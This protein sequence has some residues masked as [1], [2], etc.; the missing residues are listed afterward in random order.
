MWWKQI[1]ILMPLTF[2][3]TSGGCMEI[4]EHS[5]CD[6]GLT[7]PPHLQC[8]ANDDVCIAGP[9][10]NGI[11]DV[12]AGEVCDDGNIQPEDGC[13]P[14]CRFEVDDRLALGGS[15][16]CALS[17][18]GEFRCWGD[19]SFGQLGYGDQSD[20]GDDEPAT[21]ARSIGFDSSI[22]QLVAGES[23]TCALLDTGAVRCWGRG[24]G[25]QL[26]YGNPNHINDPLEASDV[27][28]I[29]N[30]CSVGP[31]MPGLS[32][33]AQCTVIRLAAGWNHTCA[34][35]DVG[36]VRCWGRSSFGQL[37]YGN[38]Q[39]IGDNE[40]PASAGNVDVGG[41]VIQLVAGGN[42]TCA[43]LDTGAVRCWGR[44]TYGQLGYGHQLYIG[45]DE[46]PAVAGNVDVGGYVLQL[47]AGGNRTC[48]LLASGGVRCWGKGEY[49][50]L[51][52]VNQNNIG[53]DETP[54]STGNV[55][56]GS[57]RQLAMG[58]EHTCA[59]D[60]GRN[61]RCWGSGS[62]GQLGYG[63][64]D[65]IGDD[66]APASAGLVSVGAD[67][68]GIA[69]GNW[70]TCAV[71]VGGT[72]RC[73][74]RGNKGQLGYGNPDNIGD[75][76][77]P[78]SAPTVVTIGS[79]SILSPSRFRHAGVLRDAEESPL[80]GHDVEHLGLTQGVPPRP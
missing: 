80:I 40:T 5:V 10:G 67:V 39:N 7:C 50:Q 61:V 57:I 79:S 14:E 73:W 76:G 68:I 36:T 52:Y 41:H 18:D 65:N 3:L 66:E 17:N 21:S 42:H 30:D 8:A 6:N 72:V 70:H 69:A 63:N 23:H 74:G 78:A 35:L 15:H 48:A 28:V 4:S 60:Y 13:S 33:P 31:A 45:N 25:G 16:S 51:G 32:A 54:A 1:R 53:D 64:Q 9:C 19:G 22:I 20:I 47:A 38:A 71:L 46:K 58:G 29:G 37:G 34:L 2:L 44:G 43:L 26:G 59:L 24:D 27:N 75:T 11:I 49:G 55:I 12:I 56:G 62:Y 77:T